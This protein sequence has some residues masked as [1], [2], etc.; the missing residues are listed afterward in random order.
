[1]LTFFGGD[2]VPAYSASK[3]GVAQLTKSLAIAC[4]RVNAVAPG[5]IATPL[6]QALQDDEGRSAR[7]D[8]FDPRVRFILSRPFA[9]DP[10][11][12][13]AYNSHAL[14][15]LSLALE[16]ATGRTIEAY[17]REKLFAPLGID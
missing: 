3:G 10:G 2:L 13:F 16:C 5:W 6:T 12:R 14:Q 7:D 8:A 11:R 1:M 17:A 4:I 15:L 9:P